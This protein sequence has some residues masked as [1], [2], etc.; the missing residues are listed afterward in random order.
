MNEATAA[1][2]LLGMA[3]LIATVILVGPVWLAARALGAR[4]RGLGACFGAALLAALLYLLA[5]R[6]VPGP[7]GVLLGVAGMALAYC[8]VLRLSFFS[9]LGV[10]LV[11]S[12]LQWLILLAVAEVPA[13]PGAAG[14][15]QGSPARVIE[16]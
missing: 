14:D 15:G 4:R 1:M 6:F 5:T 3:I 13:M 2:F 8:L 9:G 11:A 10:A 12:L 7:V 16:I